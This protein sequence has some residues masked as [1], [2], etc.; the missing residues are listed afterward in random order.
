MWRAMRQRGATWR[1]YQLSMSTEST[2]KIC[3][4]PASIL[5][6]E[7]GDHAAVFKLEKAPA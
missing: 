7:G 2:Q 1:L 6:G 3:N 5:A 4:W